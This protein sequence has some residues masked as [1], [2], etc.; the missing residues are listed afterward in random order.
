MNYILNKDW[1]FL[2]MAE[3]EKVRQGR[4]QIK[5]TNKRNIAFVGTTEDGEAKETLPSAGTQF[6]K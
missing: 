3:R 5:T 6:R 4:S 2:S 1:K